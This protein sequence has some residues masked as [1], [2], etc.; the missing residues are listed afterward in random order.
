[1]GMNTPVLI[2]NDAWDQIQND[3]KFGRNL[4]EASM[5]G[6]GQLADARAGNHYSAARVLG[7]CHADVT[8]L[9]AVGGNY[10]TELVATFNGGVHHTKDQQLTLLRALA[11]DLGY[12]ISRKRTK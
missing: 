7:Y 4:Y 9:I 10:M 3:P 2:I 5:I 11:E 8:R 6:R 12:T 1:M